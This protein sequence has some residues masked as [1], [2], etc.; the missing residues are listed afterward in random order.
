MRRLA[1]ILLLLPTLTHAGDCGDPADSVATLE[2]WA[3]HPTAEEP[4]LAIDLCVET[5]RADAK[6]SR[7]ILAACEKIM[8]K[9]QKSQTCI[10]WG[11]HLGAKQLAGRDLYD[12]LLEAYKL[13]PI[14]GA[15]VVELH[16]E[17]ADPRA[18]PLIVD[19]W[20][21]GNA[22]PRST[23]KSFKEETAAW[24]RNAA[25]L[26]GKLGGPPERAFLEQQLA[27]LSD[28]ATRKSL[29]KAIAAIS[30]RTP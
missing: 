4:S 13:D 28:K 7:R 3:K 9:T 12:G 25:R 2:A 11:V 17:L 24:R 19:A 8:A 29:E 21:R 14:E 15:W 6:L 16:E 1:T 30:A 20:K 10:V 5:V 26:L 23:R 27:A 18:V 22:D